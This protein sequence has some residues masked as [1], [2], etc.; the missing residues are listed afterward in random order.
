[1]SGAAKGMAPLIVAVRPPGA[2]PGS[3]LLNNGLFAAAQ[4]EHLGDSSHWL[5]PLA[6][7]RQQAALQGIE[8]NTEDLVDLGSAAAL[9]VMDLPA[10]MEELVALRRDYPN[11]KLILEMVESVVGRLWSLDPANHRL[12]DAVVS[13]D[14]CH[15]GLARYFVHRLPA[16]GVDGW[17]GPTRDERW[18]DRRLVSMVAICKPPAPRVPRRTGIGLMRRGWRMSMSDW[19]NYLSENNS[20]YGAR[21]EVADTLARVVKDDFDLY[22]SGWGERGPLAAKSCFRGAQSASKLDFLGHYR[23]NIA[24]ENCRNR[25]GYVSEKIFDALLAGTVPVYLGNEDILKFV[26]GAAFIDARD[27]ACYTELAKFLKSMPKAQWMTMRDEGARFLRGDA[28]ATFGQQQFIDAV[29][30]AIQE[31]CGYATGAGSVQRA[32]IDTD[33]NSTQSRSSR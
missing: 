12:F 6:A 8:L 5:R 30:A 10:D 9:I 24:F 28:V 7:L 31:S 17:D 27:F 20:L 2:F 21:Q 16:A 26:P 29:L 19:W 1:M 3:T 23:F 4:Y 14:D 33:S 25:S 13:Y 15:R 32:I 18:E 22:G 11:L